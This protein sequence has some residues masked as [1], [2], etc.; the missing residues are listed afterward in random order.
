MSERELH[1]EWLTEGGRGVSDSVNEWQGD[2]VSDQQSDG[3]SE[4]QSEWVIK[5]NP[6]NC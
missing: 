6:N 5:V 1:S 4:W 3:V 2:G